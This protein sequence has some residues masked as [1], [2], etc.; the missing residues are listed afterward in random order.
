MRTLRRLVEARRTLVQDRVRITNRITAALKAYFPQ[1]LDWFRDKEAAVFAD[2]VERGFELGGG[3]SPSSALH[4]RGT[5]LLLLCSVAPAR[6]ACS[7]SRSFARY[8]RFMPTLLP[9]SLSARYMASV[10]CFIIDT[11]PGTR[12]PL[13]RMRRYT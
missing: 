11:A 1:V 7:R 6:E 4:D 2:F 3:A 5:P 10:Q 8:R 13:V 12:F 9:A